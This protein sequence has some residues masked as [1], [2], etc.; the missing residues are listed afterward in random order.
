[1]EFTAKLI[2]ELPMEG[3][4]SKAGNEWK[5]KSWIFET[6]GQYPR[7]IKV[8]AMNSRIDSLRMEVGKT[9]TVSVDAQS[10]EYNGRWYTDLSA[11]AAR[12]TQDPNNTFSQP[13]S[14]PAAPAAPQQPFAAQDPFAAAA[15]AGGDPFASNDSDDLPF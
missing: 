3:G 5:K 14:T 2:E 7:K 11:Y 13:Q 12:E 10:R 15:P 9:Y 6:F 8:E 1:M 4:V